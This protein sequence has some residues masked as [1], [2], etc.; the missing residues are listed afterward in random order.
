MKTSAM[1]GT[2]ARG[3]FS[4]LALYFRNNNIF[5]FSAIESLSFNY[6]RLH[7]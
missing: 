5:V 4:S 3:G 6:V 1:F 2:S 7:E